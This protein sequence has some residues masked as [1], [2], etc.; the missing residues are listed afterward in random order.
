MNLKIELLGKNGINKKII[1]VRS[2]ENRTQDGL[3]TYFT[4]VQHTK[5]CTRKG[6][7]G[8]LF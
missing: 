5:R 7:I 4:A 1:M 8:S 2:S 3:I 6:Y